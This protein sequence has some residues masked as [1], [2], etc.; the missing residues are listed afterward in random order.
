M[1]CEQGT[2]SPALYWWVMCVLLAQSTVA[3]SIH[4]AIVLYSVAG[5]GKLVGV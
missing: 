3:Y 5:E 4:V 2:L 1:K